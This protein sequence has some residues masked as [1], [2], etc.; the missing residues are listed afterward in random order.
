VLD[1]AK[2]V[3]RLDKAMAKV[4]KELGGIAAKL[5]NSGFVDKAPESVVKKVKAQYEEL[6]EK[7]AQLLANR[8][9]IAGMV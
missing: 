7:R 8:D 6:V 1:F 2:E 5:E 4:D 9:R 3:E